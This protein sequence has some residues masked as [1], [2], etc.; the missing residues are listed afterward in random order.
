[1]HCRCRQWLAP[2][3][4]VARP[5]SG[6]DGHSEPMMHAWLFTG[7]NAPLERIERDIPRAVGNNIL[8]AVRGSALC[9]S[10]VG[11]MDGTLTPY[12]PKKP[13]IILGHEIAGEIL[14]VG[15]E[16]RAP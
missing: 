15:P 9:H 16:V 1:M 5:E 4:A 11:R 13:P 14:S 3:I 10:D 12:M 7:A 2:K 6:E 8:I